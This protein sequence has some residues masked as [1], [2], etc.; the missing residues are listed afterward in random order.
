MAACIVFAAA[1]SSHAQLIYFD[2]FS[3]LSSA[4]LNGTAPDTRP[5]TE[6]WTAATGAGAWKADGTSTTIN[7][8]PT[9]S[10]SFLT[11]TPSSGNIYELSML[12]NITTTTSGWVALGF[13]ENNPTS[14]GFSAFGGSDVRA[15]PWTL[16]RSVNNTSNP[17]QT[18][19]FQGPGSSV[20]SVAYGTNEGANQLLMIR[21]DTTGSNWV[22]TWFVNGDEIRSLT[23]TTNP[24]INYVGF[25]VNVA[26]NNGIGNTTVDNFQL[27]AIP[28]PSTAAFLAIGLGGLIYFRRRKHR[29]QLQ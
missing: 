7:N 29:I 22:S 6:T 3:G 28:E 20:A 2:D 4:N 16:M 8:N 19:T 27:V 24:T 15:A 9:L 12:A 23:Y 17:S 21:L 11:F 10:N 25:G 14:T 18:V 1:T 13:A 5:G 26:G